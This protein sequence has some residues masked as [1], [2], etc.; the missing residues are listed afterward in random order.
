MA[1]NAKTIQANPRRIRG[2]RLLEQLVQEHMSR[3]DP[4]EAAAKNADTTHA[5]D[6]DEHTP[7][8]SAQAGARGMRDLQAQIDALLASSAPLQNQIN[9]LLVSNGGT[10]RTA[11]DKPTA[12]KPDAQKAAPV[13]A[14]AAAAPPAPKPAVDPA[15]PPGPAF[16]HARP[17]PPF[18]PLT[19]LMNC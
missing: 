12:P 14:N 8:T 5:A 3:S 16:R 13:T 7:E 11:P 15:R 10:P 6:A 18:Y 2:D 17:A 19:I 9:D 1:E 4:E